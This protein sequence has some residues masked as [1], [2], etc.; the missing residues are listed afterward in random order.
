MHCRCSNLFS[1]Y[2][3]IYI[4]VFSVQVLQKASA[5]RWNKHLIKN[6][7][8]CELN[9]IK[10]NWIERVENAHSF[11]SKTQ[12]IRKNYRQMSYSW[13]KNNENN[14]C[15]VQL[16]WLR[17]GWIFYLQ[18]VFEI[19]KVKFISCQ[20]RSILQFASYLIRSCSIN[21]CYNYICI[22]AN[23]TNFYCQIRFWWI[24]GLTSH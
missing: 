11:T 6:E 21:S 12:L 18:S 7:F 1:V 20:S 22:D 16:V 5:H 2:I 17:R 10:S 14:V 9:R 24:F 3:Y 19:H 23:C 8:T 13:M 15:N 4:N